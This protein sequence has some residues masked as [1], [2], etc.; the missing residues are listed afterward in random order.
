MSDECE[1]VLPT[2]VLLPTP[3]GLLLERR[4]PESVTTSEEL[5]RWLREPTETDSARG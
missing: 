1:E 4:V 2:V 3:C 5:F